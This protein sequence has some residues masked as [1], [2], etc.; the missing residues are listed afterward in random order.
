MAYP[1]IDKPYGLKP[2]NLIGGQSFAGA[3]RLIPIA[4][5]YAT[6]IFYGDVVQYKNDGTLIITTLQNNTSVVAGVVG[7]FLGCTFTDPNSGQK[8][9]RQDYPASTTA[10]DIMAYICDDPSTLFKAVNVTGSTAD[11]AASGLLPVA[12]TRAT[13]ISCNAELVLNTGLTSTGNS[14]MGVFINNVA[15]ILPITVVD[16]VEDT[17]NSDDEYIEFIVK[18]TQGYHRYNQTAGV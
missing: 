17:K 2:V 15:T 6:G 3:S 4:S 8:T 11:G 12:K 5:A 1:T 14:R 7:V 9:F 18:L 13:T 10:S 16:V